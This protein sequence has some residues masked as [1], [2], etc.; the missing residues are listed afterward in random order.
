MKLFLALAV[1]SVLCGCTTK[2]GRWYPIIGLGFVVVNT[3]QPEA[4]VV[5]ATL[6]GAGVTTLPPAAIIG[7][8]RSSTALVTTNGNVLLEIK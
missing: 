1:A 5:K 3:N 6:L 7:F 4:T 2:T 8:S